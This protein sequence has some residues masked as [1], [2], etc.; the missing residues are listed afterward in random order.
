MLT[1]RMDDDL[2]LIQHT[3]DSNLPCLVATDRCLVISEHVYAFTSLE[4]FNIFEIN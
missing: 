4:G 3:N 1:G 2:S